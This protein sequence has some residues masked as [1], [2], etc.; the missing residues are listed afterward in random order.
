MSSVKDKVKDKGIVKVLKSNR[1]LLIIFLI[2]LSFAFLKIGNNFLPIEQIGVPAAIGYDIE[3]KNDKIIHKVPVSIYSYPENNIKTLMIEGEA[4]SVPETREIRQLEANG[5]FIIGLEKVIIISEDA[6]RNGIN[7]LMDMLLSERTVN[8][9]AYVVVCKGNVE[10]ILKHKVE[11]KPS[12]GD[13][14]AEV[15]EHLV[16][17][18][19][20]P[21]NYRLIDTFVRVG[22]EGRSLVIP[23]VEIREGK[24]RVTGLALFSKDKMIHKLKV[25][26]F[27][28]LN[29]LRESGTRGMITVSKDTEHY[30]NFYGI[31]KRKVKAR[32]ENGKF[33]F[34]IELSLKGE[35][36]SNTLY[37][38]MAQKPKLAKQFEA[39][40]KNTVEEECREFIK[41]MQEDLK[42]DCLELGRWGISVHGHDT[43]ID[44]DK[45]IAN[46]Q[47]NVTAK[48]KVTEIGRGDY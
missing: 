11:G 12:S 18:N 7:Y 20:I 41:I 44:W 13:Y 34:D 2:S 43:G 36:I 19:F 3:K 39:D 5:K 14:L 16:D 45:A 38:N 9:T 40:V 37:G 21:N 46:S 31:S 8:D 48:V 23:Y 25:N 4:G 28:L 30:A 42:I 1:T 27:K 47:I 17:M 33:I 6:A 15:V 10:D 29:L 32:K 24:V 26:E 35:L 22:S